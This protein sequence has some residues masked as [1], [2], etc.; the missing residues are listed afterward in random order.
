MNKFVKFDDR[1]LSSSKESILELGVNYRRILIRRISVFLVIFFIVLAIGINIMLFQEKTYEATAT[2]QILHESPNALGYKELAKT[3]VKNF[4]D[5]NTQLNLFDS[6]SLFLLV[7]KSMSPEDKKNLL[8]PYFKNWEKLSKG[9]IHEFVLSR[10]KINLLRKSYVVDVSFSHRSPEVAAMMANKFA[11][12]FCE[13]SLKTERDVVLRSINDLTSKVDNQR[14]VIEDQE[15]KLLKYRET[16]GA[17]SL[18]SKDDVAHQ[19]LTMLNNA[20]VNKKLEYDLLKNS[21]LLIKEYEEKGKQLITLPFVYSNGYVEN[22]LSNMSRQRAE[23]SLLT[24]K[25]GDKYPLMVCK[26]S[27]LKQLQ[28]ELDSAIKFVINGVISKKTKSKREYHLLS[29]KFK[30]KEA[31]I[32]ELNRIAVEYN[33]LLRDLDVSLNL[34][35]TINNRLHEQI[36][37]LNVLM[38]NVTIID[39]ALPLDQHVWPDFKVEIFVFLLLGIMFGILYVVIAEIFDNR[40]RC[41]SDVRNLFDDNVVGFIKTVNQ[42]IIESNLHHVSAKINDALEKYDSRTISIIGQIPVN[43]IPCVANGFMSLGYSVLVITDRPIVFS[44]KLVSYREIDGNMG[45]MGIIDERYAVLNLNQKSCNFDEKA[46]KYI[47]EI[48]EKY[49]KVIVSLSWSEACKTYKLFGD[50]LFLLAIRYNLTKTTDILHC[51]Q[52]TLTLREKIYC[53]VLF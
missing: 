39:L 38:P 41:E 23:L 53:V 5:V 29:E 14:K 52:N 21:C 1:I 2:I 22:I 35:N 12:F 8:S 42:S 10:R 48:K 34:Y 37:Q 27:E 18:D 11:E 4:E 26:N 9:E 24:E 43:L 6:N 19:Q 32:I 15:R 31:E 7:L 17:I 46:L 36:A 13:F 50:E 3:E 28:A 51:M 44:E 33:S 30:Q 25:Y 20:L 49:D 16:Y 47:C 40:I 45:H